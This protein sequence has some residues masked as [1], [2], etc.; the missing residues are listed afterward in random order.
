MS[1]A[2]ITVPLSFTGDNITLDS[3]SFVGSIKPSNFNA[4]TIIDNING[5]VIVNYLAPYNYSLPLETISDTEG[6]LAE[7]FFTVSARVRGPDN[8]Y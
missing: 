8:Q 1:F 6:L 3:V 7:L 5:T 4:T 2:G